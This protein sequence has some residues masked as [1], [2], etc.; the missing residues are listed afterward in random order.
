MSISRGGRPHP[1]MEALRE[2]ALGYPEVRED[3]P[4]GHSAFKV[5]AKV[6]LF[7]ASDDGTLSLSVK[8][9]TS[10]ATALDKPFAEPTHYGLGKSGWVTATFEPGE[11]PPL[12]LLHAW[13]RESFVAIAPKKLAASLTPGA[14]AAKR[15][16]SASPPPPRRKRPTPRSKP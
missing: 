2:H 5:K 4:W 12:E 3:F 15:A 8:L 6:F 16:K 13:I 14:P 11:L 1:A 9:P 10:G 7:L